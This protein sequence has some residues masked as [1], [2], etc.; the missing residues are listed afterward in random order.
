MNNKY[1]ALS[2]IASSSLIA[3]QSRMSS[4]YEN[5]NYHHQ[6]G[7]CNSCCCSP[8]CCKPCCVPKPKKCIDCECYT[9][10][11]YDLQCDC[12][13]FADV[14]FLYWYARETDLSYALEVEA[15]QRT[16][17]TEDNENPDLIFAPQKYHHLDT[18]WDPGVRVGVGWNDSCDG[19]DYYLNWTWFQN[20]EK[21]STSV[22]NYGT[23][24]V[25]GSG[26]VF[27]PF[28][29]S[30]GE[31]L[32]LNPWINQGF[33]VVGSNRLII[34]W[35][36]IR[37]RWK[38]TFNQIDL[39]LGRK[40]YLSKCFVMRPYLG[41]RGAWTKIN[42]R[43]TSS[44]MATSPLDGT[45]FDFTFKDRFK[46]RNWGVGLLGGFQPTFL[47]TPC[48]QLYGNADI[49]LIWGEFEIKK[50]ENYQGTTTSTSETLLDP[51][52]VNQSTSK[53][54]QMNAI[55]DLGIGL[56]W[57]DTWCCDQYRTALDVGWEHH[58]WLDHNHR[59]KTYD[60][61][62][63]NLGGGSA[64]ARESGFRTYA[65]NTGNLCYGGLVIRFRFEF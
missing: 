19:W 12:G 36:S 21:D 2:L 28:L 24:G 46:T 37:A 60:F 10:Q 51:S 64:P 16:L 63:A 27:L 29:A 47:F 55:L 45:I 62:S 30:N 23:T 25:G 44:R 1:L 9:P 59:N 65:E 11:Y 61:F 39:E 40:Y 4:N 42:F 15:V 14:A 50:R 48:F 57:E 18:K 22:P 56:R 13:F 6:S 54:F 38:L 35:N 32:L 49:A 7:Y 34:S 17:P 8:C 5:D 43:T 3:Q 20:T 52:Y 26:D 31:S 33:H 58:I 53:F 41:L